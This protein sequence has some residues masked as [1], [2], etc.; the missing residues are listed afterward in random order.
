MLNSN[1]KQV[2]AD[3]QALNQGWIL[4]V[5]RAVEPGRWHPIFEKVARTTLLTLADTEEERGAAEAILKTFTVQRWE[6]GM[7]ASLSS[8][9]QSGA[10]LIDRARGAAKESRKHSGIGMSF[11]MLDPA[12]GKMKIR[13]FGQKGMTVD[14]RTFYDAVREAIFEWVSMV[15]DK[16][17]RD[18][19][20]NDRQIADRL[21]FILFSGSK[22][23]NIVT[24]RQSLAASDS[25]LSNFIEGWFRAGLAGEDMTAFDRQT[26][27]A[28]LH[29]VLVGWRQVFRATIPAILKEEFEKL[30][31]E[32]QS[33]QKPLL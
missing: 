6:A 28:W 14:E 29:A 23:A 32:I 12:T 16:D 26:E 11:D 21:E 24:A 18:D 7:M 2:I 10:D 8:S 4:A 3:L 19:G 20:L 27:S 1:L 30:H 22:D 25:S 31:R 33:T 5:M 13:T 15:K 9:R 17:E